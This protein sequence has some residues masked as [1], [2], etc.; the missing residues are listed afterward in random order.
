MLVNGSEQEQRCGGERH[1][2]QRGPRPTDGREPQQHRPEEELQRERDAER[3]PRRRSRCLC[4][5]MSAR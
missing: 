5:A 4:I 2:D 1:R 3:D